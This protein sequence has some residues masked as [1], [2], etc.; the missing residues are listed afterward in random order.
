METI[1][2]MRLKRLKDDICKVSNPHFK[3]GFIYNPSG[4]M[5]LAPAIGRSS[6]CPDT[7]LPPK[8]GYS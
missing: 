4:D 7:D 5:I 2:E 3:W 1:K 6:K 8:G